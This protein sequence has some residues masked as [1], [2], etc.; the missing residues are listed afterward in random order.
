MHIPNITGEH[1][2]E[3]IPGCQN[4]MSSRGKPQDS[5]FTVGTDLQLKVQC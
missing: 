1:R 3:S 4:I 2:Q 5:V